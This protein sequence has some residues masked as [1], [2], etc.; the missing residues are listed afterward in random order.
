MLSFI[1]LL[2]FL[3]YSSISFRSFELLG[4]GWALNPTS[5]IMGSGSIFGLGLVRL[6]YL[7][8]VVF[9]LSLPKSSMFY[10]VLFI[11]KSRAFLPVASSCT[12][13]INYSHFYLLYASFGNNLSSKYGFSKCYDHA[14]KTVCCK[15]LKSKMKLKST[16]ILTISWLRTIFLN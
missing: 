6:N 9:F 7:V 1:S 4:T 10:W 12:F 2:L 5:M 13:A 14:S 8:T 11:D 15:I 16:C 3:F